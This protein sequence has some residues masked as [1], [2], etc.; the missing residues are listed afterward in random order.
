MAPCQKMIS[1]QDYKKLIK[2]VELFLS[3]RQM[4]L[5][6][7]L[8]SMMEKYS[9]SQEYEKAAKYRDSYFDV[10]KTIDNQD[11]ISITSDSYIGGISLLQIRDGRLTN[12]KD[13]E[14]S[15]SDYDSETE[16]IT[17]FIKEYYQMS[18]EFDIPNEIIFS[19]EIAEEDK[20]I[21]EKWLSSKKG[22]K[23]VINP[24]KSKKNEEILEL[25][26]KNSNY[27]LQE[28]KVKS[29]QELQNS[30][31]ETGSYIQEKLKLR[32]FPHRVECFDI[33]HIQGTHT[34]ASM[35][36]FFNGMPKKSEYKKYKIKTLEEGKP[37]DFQSM[38][39]VVT[40]RYSRLLRENKEF[41]DLI[42]IDGGKG[43]LS[44]AV[45]ILNKLG[46][47]NQDIVSL[48]KR[49]EEVFIP[50]KSIPV[51]FPS[52]SQALYFFQRIRD[53]AHRFAITFHRHLRDKDALHS[54]LDNIKGLYTKSKKLLT[55]KYPNISKI[56]SLTKEE[57]MLLLSK[58]QAK[59]VYEYFNST[60]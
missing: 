15:K 47:K 26:S 37:D 31:N 56:S 50:D 57:L 35:V 55:E 32:K 1:S 30:Y 18:G 20:E 2:N 40:R 54:Q 33:S 36:S 4:Q 17:Y 48:A 53:E 59:I 13:F 9:Q 23:V 52:N 39:E 34:V 49:I 28:I 10:L 51:I 41:P 46:V 12:K 19:A 21:F 45:D 22:A 5:V 43:Q 16:I 38:R 6:E 42:I 14:V 8:K 58:N 3:G 29:L 60:R 27:H 25:A 11:I 24:K 7:E 44:S